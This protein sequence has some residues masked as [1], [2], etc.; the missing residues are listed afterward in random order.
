MGP[1]HMPQPLG[2][3]IALVLWLIYV[4]QRV[5]ED[6][7]SRNLSRTVQANLLNATHQP[8]LTQHVAE[9]RESSSVDDAP[10]DVEGYCQHGEAPNYWPEPIHTQAHIHARSVAVSSE[11]R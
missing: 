3:A 2:V 4:G 1:E 7:K 6:R 10:H 5:V 9:S 11:G 8:R